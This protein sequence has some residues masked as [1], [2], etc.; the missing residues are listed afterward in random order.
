MTMQKTDVLEL[1]YFIDTADECPKA[2]Y[3]TLVKTIDDGVILPT[4]WAVT[5]EEGEPISLIDVTLGCAQYVS[6]VEIPTQGNDPWPLGSYGLGFSQAFLQ[7]QDVDPVQYL[8]YGEDVPWLDPVDWL[9][10]RL[11]D[12]HRNP[13]DYLYMREHLHTAIETL[14]HDP[15]KQ[16]VLREMIAEQANDTRTYYEVL[17]PD[18]A[19]EITEDALL[20]EW[21][22][23]APVH[24]TLDDIQTV[25]VSSLDD[26]N[27][28]RTRY[29]RYKGTFVVFR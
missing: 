7:Q 10:E 16:Q 12:F 15:E 11:V 14:R 1:G 28:F 21:R 18:D 24:F 5:N 9:Q 8:V 27:S 20:R 17:L 23:T 25:Y 19:L 4:A 6:F 3:D 2:S 13:E 26:V 29:P 22:G